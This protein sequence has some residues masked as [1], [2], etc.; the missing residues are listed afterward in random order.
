MKFWRLQISQKAN[1]VSFWDELTFSEKEF[2]KLSYKIATLF[3]LTLF[4]HSSNSLGSSWK[5]TLP[6]EG[7]NSSQETKRFF[8]HRAQS[9]LGS[10]VATNVWFLWQFHKIF[11]PIVIVIEYS[12]VVSS[13]E[14]HHPL[15]PKWQRN[16]TFVAAR[17][18]KKLRAL[19]IKQ[20]LARFLT[21][22][23]IPH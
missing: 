21:W 8:M 1:Q 4:W 3:F 2:K 23:P 22:I 15:W 20:S 7:F 11:G 5:T 9:F 18:P 16:Q 19:C 13:W 17:D 6:Y 12:T 10:L 14:I